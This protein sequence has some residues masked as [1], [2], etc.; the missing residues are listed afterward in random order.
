ME[1]SP[2]SV[3]VTKS[4]DYQQ[5][6]LSSSNYRLQRIVPLQGS[7]TYT[8][9]NSRQQV[10]F[11][12]AGNE[13]VNFSRSY[14]CVVLDIVA[15]GANNY[16]RVFR[17]VPPISSVNV[18]TRSGQLL[19]DVDW[20]NHYTR[21][22]NRLAKKTSEFMS[23]GDRDLLVMSRSLAD[24]AN[25]VRCNNSNA[26]VPY[27]EPSYFSVSAVNAPQQVQYMIPLGSLVPESLFSMDKD[28]MF[29]ETII[30]TMNLA[31]SREI[32]FLGTGATNPI[33]G[34]GALTAPAGSNT[35]SQVALFIAT[36]QNQII[37]QQVAGL[38]ASGKFTMNLPYIHYYY[39][40][41]NGGG[42]QA[43]SLRFNTAHGKRIN[44]VLHVPVN[45][46]ASAHLVYDGTNFL[47]QKITQFYSTVNNARQLD[48]NLTCSD[49]D[50][51]SLP[52]TSWLAVRDYIR[53]TVAGLSENV[54]L[55]NFF[56]YDTFDDT[57]YGE[58]LATPSWNLIAGKNLEQEVKWDLIATQTGGTNLDHYTFVRVSKQL[59][60]LPNLV[61]VA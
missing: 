6:A 7:L 59:T 4:L 60:I 28:I 47:S 25:A 51:A 5:K 42:Q 17:D 1:E 27:I 14:L 15:Q 48:F 49:T 12:I 22:A 43:I 38:V 19:L 39:N 34:S 21:I 10:Q 53:G 45:A 2:Q 24:G 40:N 33:T 44:S 37:K 13:L 23:D 61:T 11:E 57:K 56:I 46:S 50:D 35:Y 36:E 8:I 9:N 41:R 30:I 31:P 29:P 58:D 3:V 20:V 55:S 54:Y 18:R 16:S 32:G 52:T 26:N